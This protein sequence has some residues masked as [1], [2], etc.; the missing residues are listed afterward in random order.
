[1]KTSDFNYNLPQELIAQKPAIPR[2]TSRFL[3]YSRKSD[4]IL[5]D[6]FYN[7]KK[8]LKSGDVL[9]FNNTKV[10]PARLILNKK[11]GG[12]VEVFLL[13]DLGRGKWECLCKN[14]GKAEELY[15][16]NHAKGMTSKKVCDISKG[17]ENWIAKF[18]LNKKD[19]NKFLEQHGQTP[20]P[21]YIK[22]QDSKS[23]RQKYQTIYAKKSGSA[24]A[25]TAGLH[26]TQKVFKDLEKIGVQKEFVTL[27][28][29]LGTFA[30]VKTQKI[31]EHKMHAEFATID[32][33]TCARLNK[34]KQEGR[35]II[36]VGTTTVRVLE[37]SSSSF[38]K[39]SPI[40]K[41]INP[42]FYPGYKFKFVN[43]LIT[44]FHLPQSTLLMLVSAFLSQNKNKKY[45]IDKTI[46]IYK[47]AVK[48]KYRFF[49]FGD[50]MFIE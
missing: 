25:P 19:F 38:G 8:Y 42:F 22:T 17:K 28:V 15:F 41:E 36:A 29:G 46:E 39:I 10:F 35:R 30:P 2:D 40:S 6:N 27:H 31:E 12:K 33:L 47:L 11:T 44:N 13:Q 3:V 14:L 49:S 20:L 9:V 34:A 21:P 26:F 16:K 50:A 45:G 7:I 48:K 32:K 24:A 23:I 5:H 1:M 4:K 43:A 37:S 18:N